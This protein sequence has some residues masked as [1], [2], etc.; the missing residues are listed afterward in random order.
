MEAVSLAYLK[1]GVVVRYVS[2]LTDLYG[3]QEGPEVGPEVEF[4]DSVHV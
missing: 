3:N 4:L 2:T 1:M